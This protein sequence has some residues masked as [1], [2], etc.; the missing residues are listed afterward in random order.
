MLEELQNIISE[1]VVIL[2]PMCYVIGLYLKKSELPDKLIPWCVLIIG[3][4]FSSIILNDI[5]QGCIQGTIISSVCVFG[6][7]LWKQTFTKDRR[8]K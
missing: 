8:L 2:I 5:V 4:I 6:N 3:I 7:Q 1:E